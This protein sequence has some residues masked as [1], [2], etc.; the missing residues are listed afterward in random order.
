MYGLRNNC[1]F[2]IPKHLLRYFII[3]GTN[4][5]TLCNRIVKHFLYKKDC[6]NKSKLLKKYVKVHAYYNIK[7]RIKLIKC[8]R[9]H[10]H[11]AYFYALLFPLL[12]ACVNTQHTSSIFKTWSLYRVYGSIREVC[13]ARVLLHCG[14]RHRFGRV[15][16]CCWWSCRCYSY[17]RV[18]T[19]I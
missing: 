11:V 12:T 4:K 1:T 15:L 17:S 10:L 5:I 7:K 2:S 14:D 19:A 3:F 6:I 13:V 16:V 8:Q 9:Q 18:V